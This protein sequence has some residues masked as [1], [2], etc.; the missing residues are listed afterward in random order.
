MTATGVKKHS[1]KLTQ[2]EEWYVD[3]E[4]FSDQLKHHTR[5]VFYRVEKADAGDDTYERARIPHEILDTI[6]ELVLAQ[7]LIRTVS[8][9]T[10]IVRAR[11]HK[12]NERYSTVKE[13]GPP[14]ND[15]TVSTRMSPAGIPMF[16][17]SQREDTALSEIGG[18]EFATV[19]KFKALKD[20]KVLD[21]TK[22]PR[23]PS[24]FDQ[25][26]NSERSALIFLW[27]FLE[28]LTK[29]IEKDDRV[30][31]EYVPT[32]VVTEY[33]RRVF[34]DSEDAELKGVVYPSARHEG[35]ISYVFFVDND[36]CTQDDEGDAAGEPLFSMIT[37]SVK[38]VDLRNRSTPPPVGELF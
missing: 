27:N 34:R 26:N 29:P 32:Q 19:A 8:S 6:G 10:E 3:W 14:H 12:E 28:D 1:Y 22:I 15:K 25:Q 24:L 4:D 16:Y 20:I 11:L 13:L 35:G 30:H 21:L 38:Q 37:S 17:G 18:N 23:V 5:Y 2:Q 36:E 33:F 7:E 9:G 31:I